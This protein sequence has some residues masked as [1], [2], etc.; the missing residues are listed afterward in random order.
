MTIVEDEAGHAVRVEPLGDLMPFVVHRQE[1]VP[2]ARADHHPGADGR[3]LLRQ[4]DD[5]ARFVFRFVS[6]CKR[7]SLRPK[8]FRGRLRG[9]DAAAES[10]TDRTTQEPQAD[11]R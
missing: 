2:T 8:E 1:T 3:V 10:R 5:Q 7:R 6:L 4:I 11:P 9:A